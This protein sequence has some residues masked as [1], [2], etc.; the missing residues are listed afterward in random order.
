MQRSQF[1]N[2]VSNQIEVT[3]HKVIVKYFKRIT[4]RCG[5]LNLKGY[6]NSEFNI[7][8]CLE[9]GEIRLIEPDDCY[10]DYINIRPKSELGYSPKK[11]Y[12]INGNYFIKNIGDDCQT[13]YEIV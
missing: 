9:Y 3:N 6:D 2:I 11:W 7:T 8:P 12:G 5:F 4:K 1:D 10:S 13:I